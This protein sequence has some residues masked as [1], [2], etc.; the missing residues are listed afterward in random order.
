LS[1]AEAGIGE[2]PTRANPQYHYFVEQTAPPDSSS[3]HH[4][5][6]QQDG[7]I[8]SSLKD[9]YTDEFEEDTSM[10][11]WTSADNQQSNR[12]ITGAA[13]RGHRTTEEGGDT[14]VSG[15]LED[16]AT[17]SSV[18]DSTRLRASDDVEAAA[19]GSVGR[20]RRGDS[21]DKVRSNGDTSED[22]NTVTKADEVDDSEDDG[23]TVTGAP[24]SDF[25]TY[26][27]KVSRDQQDRAVDIPLYS[28]ARP[29]M[30][31]F[32]LSWIAFFV[33]FFVWFSM[34]PLLSEIA[35]TLH[36]SHEELWTSSCLAV[37]SSA[38]TR[39]LVGPFNDKYGAR[40]VMAVTLV[41]AAIPTGLA[42]LLVHGPLSLYLVRFFIGMAGSAFVTSQYW[43]SS[44]FCAEIAGTANALVRMPTRLRL[45]NHI[46]RRSQCTPFLLTR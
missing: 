21:E 30:R 12:P 34:S 35:S 38:I 14:E 42:G 46:Q 43:T 25:R 3:N 11:C 13:G 9:S 18:D 4:V 27:V 1:G 39:V 36:L 31:A 15:A 28:F 37:A 24:D 23:C 32:H 10:G 26:Q 29:H 5:R 20:N 22:E 6:D 40:W 7:T 2:L 16:D 45:S 41:V 44:V 8:W 33:A 19:S 17:D